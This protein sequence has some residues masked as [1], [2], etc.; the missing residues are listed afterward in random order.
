[1]EGHNVGSYRHPADHSGNT[2]V[3]RSARELGLHEQMS[4]IPE[5]LATVEATVMHT[6]HEL[7]RHSRDVRE[8][9]DHHARIVEEKF[10]HSDR[11]REEMAADVKK[12]LAIEAERRGGRKIMLALFGLAGVGGGAVGGKIAAALQ[13]LFR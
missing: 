11:K 4:T 12:L 1:M 7:D 5:R 2:G 10:E 13:H 6:R 8:R 3:E 9:L